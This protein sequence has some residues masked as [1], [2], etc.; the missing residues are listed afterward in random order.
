MRFLFLKVTICLSL[1]VSLLVSCS[2][3]VK[4]E[5]NEKQVI[6]IGLF[7]KN[8]TTEQYLR[9]QYF[10]LY[11]YSH[12][13]IAIEFVHAK[14]KDPVLGTKQLLNSNNPP[15]IVLLSYAV[16][17]EFIDD[18]YLV[19]LD[20]LITRD[21][22]DV[23]G[24]AQGVISGLRDFGKGSLYALSPTFSSSVLI[25]NENMFRNAGVTIPTDGMTWEE[26]FDKA[27]QIKT[28]GEKES[29]GFSFSW[30]WGGELNESLN[31]YTGPLNLHEFDKSGRK[32]T[33][34]TPEWEKV[35]TT[36][37]DLYKEKVTPNE[38]DI[39]KFK[40][41]S[42]SNNG[43]INDNAFLSGK[44]AMTIMSY[45]NFVRMQKILKTSGSSI[46]FDWNIATMPV[47]PGSPNTGTHVPMEPV[48][49]INSKSPNIEVSW[50]LIKFICGDEW[51]RAK[52]N[53]TDNL[54]AR[55]KYNKTKEGLDYNI[56][57]FYKL[58]PPVIDLDKA[59]QFLSKPDLYHVTKLG[60]E[61]LKKALKGEVS[62]KEALSEWESEGN[63]LLK[64]IE[65]N[66]TI[67][68][69]NRK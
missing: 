53:S 12:D 6:R 41:E 5:K 21:K 27:R 56:N 67:D 24:L 68:T 3:P 47:H 32:M 36:I 62:V 7:E 42:K 9:D 2:L 18:N 52:T 60:E 65:A 40:N 58:K 1:L 48:L 45:R 26:A 51:A 66:Q 50:D 57:A 16:I 46:P 28:K 38:E 25:Y 31:L 64:K 19:K 63:N 34:N 43:S 29:F 15:D 49:A 11:E 44:I 20:P 54:L 35:W 33:V 30:S 4:Q 39:T 55:I 17:G 61:K 10:S 59:R 23:D 37:Y 22:Y 14:H 69:K 8:E 13:N